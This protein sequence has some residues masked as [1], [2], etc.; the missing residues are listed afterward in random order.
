MHSGSHGTCST[1]STLPDPQTRLTFATSD[2]WHVTWSRAAVKDNWFLYPW[3]EEVSPFS[4]DNV[5]HSPEPVKDDSSVPSIHWEWRITMGQKNP[6]TLNQKDRVWKAPGVFCLYSK[7]LALSSHTSGLQRLLNSYETKQS[8][9]VP[10]PPKDFGNRIY[11]QH[12]SSLKQLAADFLINHSTRE[13]PP[14]H[15]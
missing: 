4:Y 3:D 9:S 7:S 14:T 15:S 8:L 1:H 10:C 5:L 12:S 13:L 2:Y 11:S 6:L